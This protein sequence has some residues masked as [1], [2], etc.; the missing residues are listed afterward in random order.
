MGNLSLKTD[1]SLSTKL[2]RQCFD[3]N[4]GRLHPLFPTLYFCYL[5]ADVVVL[6]TPLFFLLSLISDT[7]NHLISLFRS[8]LAQTGISRG[9]NSRLDLL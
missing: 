8:A 2:K 6:F 4:Q 9:Q 3:N 1:D 5:V 7:S